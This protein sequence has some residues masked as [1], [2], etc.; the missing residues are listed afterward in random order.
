MAGGTTECQQYWGECEFQKMGEGQGKVQELCRSVRL[1]VMME[2]YD[3][4]AIRA[5]NGS[6]IMGER[7][8]SGFRGRGRDAWVIQKA[9]RVTGGQD[10]GCGTLFILTLILD[11]LFILTLYISLVRKATG[12]IN[13]FISANI[14]SLTFKNTVHQDIL[15][16]KSFS[17]QFCCCCLVQTFLVS[18]EMNGFDTLDHLIY[19]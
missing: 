4:R 6:E 19:S 8:G 10:S 9:A 1:K 13:A 17:V 3:A 11:F 2:K 14:I 18:A 5:G 12:S 16:K 7:R 15:K